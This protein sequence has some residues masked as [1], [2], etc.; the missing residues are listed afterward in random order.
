M[1]HICVGNLTNISSDNGLSPGR[2]QTIIQINA[3]ILLIRTNLNEILTEIHT[4]PFKKIYLK[5]SSGK[6]RLFCLGLN[7]L[8]SF[9][10]EDKRL[11]LLLGQY[12][13][14]VRNQGTSS[15]GIDLI[16]WNVYG[17]CAA[18]VNWL[19]W[20][21]GN[22]CRSEDWF[23]VGHVLSLIRHGDTYLKQC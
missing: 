5:M 18:R 22:R 8:N 2:H 23:I 6:R 12:H 7:V 20:V 21:W 11:R 1:T 13:G 16:T 10:M 15:Q 17:L 3:G 19:V 9:A 14:D 4:L